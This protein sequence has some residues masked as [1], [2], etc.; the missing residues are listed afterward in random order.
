MSK[1]L[2][3]RKEFFIMDR[4]PY[5]TDEFDYMN[6]CSTTDCTGL[7]PA[8]P[9]NDEEYDSYNDI[10]FFQPPFIPFHQPQNSEKEPPLT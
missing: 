9:I 6:S 10:Y 5:R 4:D 3:D 1:E 2:Y 8:A 7:I